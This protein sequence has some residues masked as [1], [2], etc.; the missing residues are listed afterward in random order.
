MMHTLS[1]GT[2]HHVE[3]SDVAR[4]SINGKNSHQMMPSKI[5]EEEDEEVDTESSCRNRFSRAYNDA[6]GMLT[7]KYTLTRRIYG[8]EAIKEEEKPVDEEGEEEEEEMKD[9]WSA[10]MSEWY[11][12]VHGI[13]F[14]GLPEHYPLK[15]KLVMAKQASFVGT[16]WD[17]SQIIFSIVA[18][19]MY[20][21]ELGG[22]S[23][24]DMKIFGLVELILTQFFLID[25]IFNW[26]VTHSTVSYLMEP[27][28]II[29]I[30]TIVP[31]YVGLLELGGGQTNLSIFRFVR[32]LRLIRILRAFRML[33]GLSGVKR[34]L[35]TLVL[36]LLS[37]IFLASGIVHLMENDIRQQL[38]LDCNFVNE[39]T[40]WLPSCVEDKETYQYT[41]PNLPTYCDCAASSCVSAFARND[42][43]GEPTV[44]KCNLRSFFHCFYYVIVTMSTVGYGVIYP[45]HDYSRAITIVFIVASMVLIPLQVNQLNELLQA[46]SLFR[47][48]YK[49]THDSSHILVCGYVNSRH[50]LE[51]FAREFFHPDR[52]LFQ[53][54]R[55][56]ILNPGE[57]LEEV[58][59]LLINPVF[60]SKLYYLIGSPLV[61]TDLV[62]ARA[63]AAV[64]VFFLTN[65]EA[66][67]ALCDVADSMTILG[68][69]SLSNF[70]PTLECFAQI[71][72]TGGRDTLRDSSADVIVCLDDLRTILQARNAIVHGYATFIELLFM[73]FGTIQNKPERWYIEYL[74]G[75][76]GEIYLIPMNSEYLE[77][78]SYMWSFVVEGI[79]IEFN[80]MLMGVCNVRDQKVCLNPDDTDFEKFDSKEAFFNFYNVGIIIAEEESMATAIG[81]AT[82]DDAYVERI[83]SK[84]VKEEHQFSIRAGMGNARHK[85]RR[86]GDHS[87]RLRNSIS[88]STASI[89]EQTVNL[90][91]GSSAGLMGFQLFSTDAIPH[92]PNMTIEDLIDSVESYD[93]AQKAAK[94]MAEE[95]SDSDSSKESILSEVLEEEFIGE[96]VE[97][98]S[99]NKSPAPIRKKCDSSDLSV[100]DESKEAVKS[101]LIRKLSLMSNPS[102]DDN[103]LRLRKFNKIVLDAAH[104]D[105]H[106][107]VFGNTSSM[108]VFINELRRNIVTK[109]SNHPILVV[110]NEVPDDWDYIE[111][112]YRDVYLLRGDITEQEIYNNTNIKYAYAL[113]SLAKRSEKPMVSED[114]NLDADTLFAFLKL[115][116]HVPSNVFFTVELVCPPNLAVLNSTVMKRSKNILEL[117]DATDFMKKLI[118]E[119]PGKYNANMM[120]DENLRRQAVT[121]MSM[122]ATSPAPLLEKS[123]SEGSF[124]RKKKQKLDE[125]DDGL[126]GSPKKSGNKNVPGE[127]QKKISLTNNENVKKNADFKASSGFWDATN[128][129]HVLPVFASGTAFVPSTFDTILCQSFYNTLCPIICDALVCGQ[130]NKTA[131]SVQVPENFVGGLFI[132]IFRAFISRNILVLGMYRSS[133]REDMSYMP[134]VYT[135]PFKDSILRESD[136]LYVIADP[137]V[138]KR[139][140]NSLQLPFVAGVVE[141]TKFLGN[142]PS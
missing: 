127:T 66:H 75:A 73:S 87:G 17:I 53:D 3:M 97:I 6:M 16:F 67:D 76:S 26:F 105:N 12:Y 50:K 55:A 74:R 61:A 11:L 131:Y 5:V 35:I 34:Q 59:S 134:Y 113:V 125:F 135:C 79:F 117:K 13:V 27:L 86:H 9:T 140:M 18:C 128:S 107:I 1:K 108:S 114:D 57:P 10:K 32:I 98:K 103:N 20:V 81:A 106:V 4:D 136:Q 23:Y 121:R 51:R 141:G 91:A 71:T 83:V 2:K 77:A 46:K 45:T 118:D 60:D 96:K 111:K 119:N 112:T 52:T 101:F 110:S 120:G 82:S 109:V 14:P 68:T 132:D 133:S 129:H 137:V 62:K 70:N 31:V 47:E 122:C 56:L 40:G 43:R 22:T 37:L 126:P 63:D 24:D 54:L 39:N 21:A 94:Q 8:P 89:E 49:T 90:A 30:L 139:S 93:A 42:A 65:S 99:G 69:L 41:D 38:Y 116:S 92:V 85:K 64:A 104:L 95:D 123:T 124:M 84:I 19:G 44:V 36:T 72:K 142:L 58:K 48:P 15:K 80:V 102:A 29:D 138:L 7:D 88:L 78:L 33:R 100:S 28:V 130:E 115:E 25:F